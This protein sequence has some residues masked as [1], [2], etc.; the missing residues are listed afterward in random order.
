MYFFTTELDKWLD[1]TFATY[2][3]EHNSFTG[4]IYKPGK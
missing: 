4:G 3:N 1:A 2:G